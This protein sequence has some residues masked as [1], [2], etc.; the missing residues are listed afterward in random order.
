MDRLETVLT[1]YIRHSDETVSEMR[2]DIAEMRQW[3]VQSQKQWGEIAQKSSTFV[4]DIVAPNIPRLAGEVLGLGG[5]RM[6][7]FPVRACG[8]ATPRTLRRCRSLT[9]STPR[10]QAG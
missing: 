7:F 1:S 4:E 3:R 6:K 8:F 2:Q 10:G 9:T 5:V